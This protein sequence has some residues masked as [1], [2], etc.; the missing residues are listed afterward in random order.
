MI[1]IEN[2]FIKTK[3]NNSL[4][5][6]TLVDEIKEA[7]KEK[8]KIFMEMGILLYQ[9]IRE[10]TIEDA[11][12][13]KMSDELVELDKLIYNNRLK[14][15]GANLQNHKSTCDCGSIID[16]DSKFCSQCGQMIEADEGIRAIKCLSCDSELDVDSK[17]CVCCGSKLNNQIYI[18][19]K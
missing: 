3:G 6:R 16:E 17:Y 10:N 1:K 7:E 9:K 19:E 15:E 12:F 11:S 18:D 8:A 5:N 2:R 13:E 14:I 4:E